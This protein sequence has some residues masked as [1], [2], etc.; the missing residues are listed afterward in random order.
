MTILEAIPILR[1][2][3]VLER[4]PS[5]RSI[6]EYALACISEV[7]KDASNQHN[8]HSNVI[9]C[10]G[11]NYIISELLSSDGCPNCGVETFQTKI[12]I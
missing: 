11:C 10:M 12:N 7:L 6:T 8:Q 5:G 1:R 3:S 4:T 9:Q 2:E